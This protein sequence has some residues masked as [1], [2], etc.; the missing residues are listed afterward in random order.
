MLR[1]END[2]DWKSRIESDPA[3]CGGRPRV[4]GTRLTVEFLLGLKAAGWPETQ[5]LDEYPHL[6]AEDLRAVFA[7]AQSMIEEETYLPLTRVA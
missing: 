1:E 5:I 2:M 6:G 4:K 7:F 3:I